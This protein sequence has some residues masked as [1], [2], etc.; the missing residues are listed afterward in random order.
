MKC[1]LVIYAMFVAAS[2]SGDSLAELRRTLTRFPAEAPFAASAVIEMNAATKGDTSREGS[3]SFDV[4]SSE[5][6]FS[7][8]VSP[9]TLH[10]AQREAAAKKLNPNIATPT[11]T[12]MAALNV[13]DVLDSI[14]IAA[15]L[16]DDLSGA[17]VIETNTA[18]KPLRVT[19]KPSFA[20]QSRFVAEPKIEL[21]I[22]IGNDGVPVAA[23]RVSNFSAGF[24]PF[25]GNN[26]RTERWTVARHGDR[27]YSARSEEENRASAIGKTMSSSRTV[28]Y[29]P[30]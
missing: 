28:L 5:R 1:W 3:T 25:K 11:R 8:V 18:T 16:L 22:W 13:F 7:I 17:T 2:A 29:T 26:V 30:K 19:V 6:G 23:E 10:S 27:L 14:D 15:M 20:T 9:A 24:G 21:K 4:E 12:A